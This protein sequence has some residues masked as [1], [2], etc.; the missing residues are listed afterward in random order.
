M[1]HPVISFRPVAPRDN[2]VLAR[3]IRTVFEEFDAPRTGTV[4]ADPSTD[5]LFELFQVPGAMLWVAEQEGTAVGC[6]GIYPTEGLPPGTAELVKCYLAAHA[7][8]HGTGKVLV[9]KS[10]DTARSM[11][12][13][14]VYLESL[15]DFHK[16]IRLYEQ[17]GFRLLSQ[18]LGNTGHNSCNIWMLK[19]L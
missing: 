3:V 1:Q 15:P 5:H 2:P 14:Q 13:R 8:G 12:Y 7:R 10:L 4:F 18:R 6:G 19:D 11:G 9:E 17:Q 16:A